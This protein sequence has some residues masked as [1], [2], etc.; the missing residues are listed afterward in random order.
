MDFDV[1]REQWI[2]RFSIRLAQGIESMEPE[3]LLRIAHEAWAAKGHLMP[4]EVA[5]AVAGER[6]LPPTSL[7]P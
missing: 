5:D 3:A 4:E 1:T 6:R 2:D 7:P